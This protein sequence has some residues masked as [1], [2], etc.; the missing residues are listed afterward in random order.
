[1][2]N[3]HHDTF[4]YPIKQTDELL[5]K[6]GYNL[7]YEYSQVLEYAH[8]APGASVLDIATG[9]GR[10]LWCLNKN[11]Y[12]VT[13][14]DINAD[15]INAAKQLPG[16]SPSLSLH[17]ADGTNLPYSNDYWQ[18]IVSS[19]T[20]HETDD[21][22]KM[23]Y[24]LIRCLSADGS[25]ILCEFNEHG[26]QIIDSIHRTV[27]AAPHFRGTYTRTDLQTALEKSFTEIEYH[28]LPLNDVWICRKKHTRRTGSSS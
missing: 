14:V 24:E 22:L 13:S 1:M 19:N 11:N 28:Q 3:N 12:T 16:L 20:L 4:G 15:V 25:L 26:F 2:N 7:L 21:S 18:Y 23:I 10:M 9:S 27:H 8:I 5:L 17:T 6:S